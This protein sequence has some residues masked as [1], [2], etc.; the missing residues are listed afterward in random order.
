M[1]IIILLQR[2]FKGEC[3]AVKPTICHRVRSSF[4]LVCRNLKKEPG[5]IIEDLMLTYYLLKMPDC[6]IPDSVIPAT[7][8]VIEKTM[9]EKLSKFLTPIWKI[10][11]QFIKQKYL[12]II[13]ESK[14]EKHRISKLK[15]HYGKRWRPGWWY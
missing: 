6:E 2:L 4:Y 7:I 11:T 13:N 10:Q 8:E 9:I 5:S 14:A 3:I 1:S 15:Q 12:K